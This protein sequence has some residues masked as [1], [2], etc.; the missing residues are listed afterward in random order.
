M[1][2]KVPQNIDIEDRILGPLTLVQFIY[3][4]IGMGAAYT[5]VMSLPRP[6]SYFLAAPVA[7]FTLALAFLKINER[8]FLDFFLAMIQYMG[9]SKQRI[10]KHGASNDMKVVIYKTRKT[11]KHI[12]TKEVSHE[13]IEQLAK[14]LDNK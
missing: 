9:S 12:Q 5:I 2:Y 1:R 10:W 3:A 13:K 11:E 8:P 7:L 14:R 6:Y 4:V